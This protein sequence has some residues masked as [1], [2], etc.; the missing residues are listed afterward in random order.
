M[1]K[2]R[3]DKALEQYA[4]TV[5]QKKEQVLSQAS[6]EYREIKGID[7]RAQIIEYNAFVVYLQSRL[8]AASEALAMLDESEDKEAKPI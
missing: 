8:R 4:G 1:D 7:A 2:Q 5:R 3:F 6:A